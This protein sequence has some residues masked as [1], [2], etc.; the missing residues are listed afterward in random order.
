MVCIKRGLPARPP[1]LSSKKHSH[2]FPSSPFFRYLGL[3]CS[4]PAQVPLTFSH[5]FLC[6][7]PAR[8][9]SL[10]QWMG[11]ALGGIYPCLWWT[12][13]SPSC[14]LQCL[15]KPT[16]ASSEG[17]R[18]QLLHDTLSVGWY[19]CLNRNFLM[20]AG[21]LQV[22]RVTSNL[23]ELL[24]ECGTNACQTFFVAVVSKPH[25]SLQRM[26][27]GCQSLSCLI[28]PTWYTP[29]AFLV[30]AAGKSLHHHVT[31]WRLG[32]LPPLSKWRLWSLSNSK[33][34]RPAW[35]QAETFSR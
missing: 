19:R 10:L 34:K 4:W 12:R 13:L 17:W 8:S 25:K 3:V 1:F 33:P 11:L 30:W 20:A 32:G 31:A 23:L 28:H 21:S 2:W 15:T 26:F 9:P 35:S 14:L 29:S 7:F 27:Y 22:S 5:G 16:A 6:F 18:W 24:G